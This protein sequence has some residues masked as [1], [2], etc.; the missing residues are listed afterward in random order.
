MEIS[1]KKIIGIGF[2]VTFVI[3][4]TGV[5]SHAH[6]IHVLDTS[7]SSLATKSISPM[8]TQVFK[9]VA[10]LG[11]P[12]IV[13]GLTVLLCAYLWTRQGAIISLWIAGIQ[14]FGSAF[15]AIMKQLVARSRPLH[16]LVADTGFSFPSGHTFC[17]TILVF[18]I[19]ML[20]L[21]LIQDQENQLIAMLAGALWIGMVAVS[22]IYLRDHFASDV[23]ASV[24]FD[25]GYWLIVTAYEEAIKRLLK[26]ILPR[27]DTI[28]CKN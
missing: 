1:Q 13:I 8:N 4:A 14:L 9:I 24:F 16:Q 10:F 18:S 5:V 26:R 15:V 21:P 12:V 7:I 22:R 27:K 25:S 28:T 20:C 11:S 17:T 19:L 23:L 3:L 6:W 2:L